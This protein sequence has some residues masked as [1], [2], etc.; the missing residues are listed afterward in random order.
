MVLGLS[1]FR[2]LTFAKT[3]LGMKVVQ[4]AVSYTSGSCMELS[5]CKKATSLMHALLKYFVNS[6]R[7][8]A[9]CNV[10]SI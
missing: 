8:L 4:C 3:C 5:E 9:I 6:C 10:C 2:G 1:C 7:D